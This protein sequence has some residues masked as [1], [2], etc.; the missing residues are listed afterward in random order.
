MANVTVF[1]GS[2]LPADPS[3]VEECRALGRFLGEANLGLVYGGSRIGLMGACADATLAAGGRVFGVLP[4]RLSDREIAHESLTTLDLVETMAE[5]KDKLLSLGD[6]YVALPG[7]YGTLDEFFEALTMAQLGYHE[8]PCYLV[9]SGGYWDGI[10]AWL[11]RAAETGL[12]RAAHR[13]LCVV[14][15]DVAA[16]IEKLRPLASR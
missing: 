13:P 7:G 15:P 10:I 1:C 11:D 2:A 3:Y 4:H 9:N 14:V 6:A 12:V 8:R 16:L 5:R